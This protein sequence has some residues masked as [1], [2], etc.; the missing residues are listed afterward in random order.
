MPRG[1]CSKQSCNGK[2]SHH[3]RYG[4]DL[5]YTILKEAVERNFRFPECWAGAKGIDPSCLD[6]FFSAAPND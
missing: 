4:Y 6:W 3:L 5:L 2:H 1:S